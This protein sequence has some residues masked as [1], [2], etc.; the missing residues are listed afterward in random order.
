[1]RNCPSCGAG[2]PEGSSHC[3]RCAGD[4]PAEASGPANDPVVKAAS[5]G[6]GNEIEHV[7]RALGGL[8]AGKVWSVAATGLLVGRD[9]LQSQ[10]LLEGPEISRRHAWLFFASDGTLRIEDLSVNGTYLNDRKVRQAAVNVGNRIRFG[11]NQDYTFTYETLLRG[12]KL[13]PRSD[14]PEAPVGLPRPTLEMQT[15]LGA[16]APHSRLQFVIDQYVVQSIPLDSSRV[17]LGRAKGPGM[18]TIDHPSV[19]ERHAQVTVSGSGETTLRDLGSPQGTM[20]NGE[21]VGE[22][23]LREGDLIQ[24]GS[25]ESRL[26]LYREA[27]G[28]A[29]VLR[30]I[31]LA[32]GVTRLGRDPSSEARLDHPTVS[33]FHAEIRKLDNGFELVDRDSTNGTFVNG[34][35]ISRHRLQPRDRISIGAVQLMFDGSQIEGS[36]GVWVRAYALQRTVRD[37]NLGRPRVLLDRISLAIKPQEFVGLLGPSGAGKTTL[38]SAL[39][40]LQPADRGRVMVNETELYSNFASLRAMMGQVPQEDILHRALMV[41]EGLYYAARL[42]LPDDYTEREIWARVQEVIEAVEIGQRAG[43]VIDQLSGGERKRV[44][45]ALELLSAPSLLFLDEPVAGQDPFTETKMMQLFR[46]IANRG[47]TVIMTTHLLGGY[48]LLDK[49]LVLVGGRLAYCGPGE[50]MLGYFR[51]SRP[52]DVYDTLKQKP[53][54]QWAEQFEKSD[55]YAEHVGNPLGEDPSDRADRRPARPRSAP[56][57]QSPSGFT[58]LRALLSRLLAMK[59]KDWTNI[60][61]VVLPPPVIALLLGLMLGYSPNNPKS[62]FILVIVGLWFGGSAAVREIVDEQAVYRRERQRGLSISAYLGSK[63]AYVA[64]LAAVQAPLFVGVATLMG[65]LENHFWMTLFVMWVMTV[66]G[67]LIGLLISAV[68]SSA[69]KALAIFPL[70]LIP[71]LLL[72][73]LFIPA[74]QIKE[75]NLMRVNTDCGLGDQSQAGFSRQEM[76]PVLRYGVSPLMVARWGLEELADVYIHDIYDW[77]RLN[78]ARERYSLLLLGSIAITFHPDE[79]EQACRSIKALVAQGESGPGGYLRTADASPI[80]NGIL[81]AFAVAMTAGIAAALKRKDKDKVQ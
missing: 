10:L 78:E 47:S 5:R 34:V 28:R 69:E 31:E 40:G 4:L 46:K 73:G 79:A 63:L 42:R 39:C 15:E 62:L 52:Q 54:E 80:C 81:A 65:V 1:M 58:Q 68:A 23:K 9:P 76:P 19:A 6:S 71:Q 11:L 66:Q 14:R 49:V 72:A 50:E 75:L 60:A 13:A 51:A 7:L 16:A 70:A 29:L 18:I 33:R 32:R 56:A 20:V 64:G 77:Q 17:S 43:V 74:R 27:R 41:K 2:N 57:T 26:L 45:L 24:L 36:A 25:C 30:E 3:R 38:M 55:L 37:P 35:R 12:G 8:M 67:A 22:R 21:R 48:S 59:S 61:G 44:S 53:P